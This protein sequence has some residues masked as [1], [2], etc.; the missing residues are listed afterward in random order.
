MHRSGPRGEPWSLI[1]NQ[2][3]S[4]PVGI[5]HFQD[6]YQ[7]SRE[8]VGIPV[9]TQPVSSMSSRR[10]AIND[11]SASSPIEGRCCSAGPLSR[12][13]AAAPAG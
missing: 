8:P 12:V 5:H 11:W 2:T 4:T 13:A 6:W 9:I 3:Q 10:L 7:Y 1:G